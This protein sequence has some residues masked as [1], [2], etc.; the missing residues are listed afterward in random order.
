MSKF[1]EMFE[2]LKERIDDAWIK[3]L[4]V[5]MREQGI[6]VT[7]SPRELQ[8][9]LVPLIREAKD[10]KMSI[11]AEELFLLGL[12]RTYTPDS[13][14]DLTGMMIVSEQRQGLGIQIIE[15]PI[16]TPNAIAKAWVGLRIPFVESIYYPMIF[17]TPELEEQGFKS[18]DRR[19]YLVSTKVALELLETRNPQ[20]AD[21]F[22]QRNP[23]WAKPD[24]VLIFDSDSSVLVTM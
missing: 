7:K 2:K 16:G 23:N 10:I 1:P 8:A 3:F 22:K 5:L 24:Q 14:D 19:G 15:P 12:P 17:S 6:A 20:A 9:K 13:W 18:S 11:G 21:Y 4:T